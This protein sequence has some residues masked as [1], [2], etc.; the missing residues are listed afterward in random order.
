MQSADSVHCSIHRWAAVKLH[1]STLRWQIVY[2]LVKDAA[3]LFFP[4][5]G[6]QLKAYGG[7]CL[8]AFDF[9]SSPAGTE[10]YMNDFFQKRKLKTWFFFFVLLCNAHKWKCQAKKKEHLCKAFLDRLS[11]HN[12]HLVTMCS[13]KQEGGM[14]GKNL[15]YRRAEWNSPDCLAQF[16][17]K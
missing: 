16:H 13:V 4:R 6:P 9:V 7:R 14:S 5:N 10:V 3:Q 17:F 1:L 8:A 11:T 2:V 15:H 12:K